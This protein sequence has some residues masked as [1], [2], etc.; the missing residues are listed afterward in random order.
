MLAENLL[1]PEAEGLFASQPEAHAG[2]KRAVA[3]VESGRVAG[4]LGLLGLGV[5]L[6]FFTG[7]AI[8]SAG[9]PAADT[10]ATVVNVTLLSVGVVGSFVAFVVHSAL[11]REA[12]EF[13]QDAMRALP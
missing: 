3:A 7:R 1:V 10:I 5:S 6:F 13:L 2:W 4:T 9:G 12:L 11:S 8:P